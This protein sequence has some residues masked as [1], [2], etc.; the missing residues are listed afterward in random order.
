MLKCAYEGCNEEGKWVRVRP[1]SL[2]TF[3]VLT[4]SKHEEMIQNG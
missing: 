1:S 3:E 2:V 4:C